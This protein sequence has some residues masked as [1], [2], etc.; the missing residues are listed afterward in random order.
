MKLSDSGYFTGFELGMLLENARQIKGWTLGDAA[1]R[2]GVSER[3]INSIETAD[4][5]GFGNEVEMLKIKL[6]IYAKKLGMGNEKIHAL[7]DA[8][9]S[10]LE[11]N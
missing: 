10:E 5:S 8:T 4:Y 11:K 2:I 1:L 6:R 3:Q 9:L 7:I